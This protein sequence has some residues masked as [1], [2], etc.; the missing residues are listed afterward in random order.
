MLLRRSARWRRPWIRWP[1]LRAPA[2]AATLMLV[3]RWLVD[4]LGT[5]AAQLRALR[6]LVRAADP[7]GPV[8]D[9]LT[10]LVEVLVGYVLVALAVRSLGL[11]PGSVGRLA[12]R[13]VLLIGP[14]AVRRALDLLVG[15]TL[16]AHA[17]LAA[18][19]GTFVG[20]GSSAEPLASTASATFVGPAS[21][22]SA[23]VA[24]MAEAWAEGIEVVRARPPSRRSAA[25]LPPW[26]G[27][28]PS[29][30]A[31][32]YTVRA[33][34]TLWDIAAARLAPGERTPEAVHRYWRRIYRANR[35]TIG[36][37]PDL[38]HPGTLLHVPPFHEHGR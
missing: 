19:P 37:E 8:L 33:G 27:G 13:T 17:A 7:V 36:P 12:R 11:L 24:G 34:D 30:A 9:L 29:K 26:L 21:S 2:L 15:G 10:L 28:G 4:T 5:P 20:R 32:G 35:P 31:P 14:V 23:A 22:A 6:D 3:E 16:L 38:I 25:P 1:W 18:P